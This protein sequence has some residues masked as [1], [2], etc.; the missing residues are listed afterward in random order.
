MYT[1]VKP[2]TLH[3]KRPNSAWPA[4][5]A[6]S[7]LHRSPQPWAER[8]ERFA[9]VSAFGFGGTNFQSV[10]GGHAT[11]MEPRHA[12]QVWPAELFCLRGA[13][14]DAAHRAARQL[15]DLA[16]EN[17]RRGRPVSLQ[18]LAATRRRDD[19]RSG[20]VRVAVV[21]RD[22][23][24]LE[25]LLHRA[26]AG[27]HDPVNGLIQ[28]GGSSTEQPRAR[29]RALPGPGQPAAGHA[30]RTFV[31]FPEIRRAAGPALD[32]AALSAGRVR[33]RAG[34][35]AAGPAARHQGAQQALGITGL[36]AEQ[37]LRRLG[38]CPDMLGGHSY[39]ELVALCA[40]GVFDPSGCSR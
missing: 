31:T 18:D 37:L 26:L 21:A 13:D 23:D 39:G 20:P 7:V 3:M 10:L 27:E 24:E 9:G 33:C 1:G 29:W 5:R 8:R 40:A 28:P 22:L 19:P 6:R 35:G 16:A 25:K 38:V 2:P 14:V 17:T 34:G 36:A 4:G 12:Q 11:T 15:A 32:R 30:G